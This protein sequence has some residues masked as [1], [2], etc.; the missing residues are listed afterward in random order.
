MSREWNRQVFL[1]SGY[2]ITLFTLYVD[3][4]FCCNLR[5]Y[6]RE[7]WMMRLQGRRDY[8]YGP[9][10]TLY[11]QPPFEIAESIVDAIGVEHGR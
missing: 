6:K 2:R 11:K 3:D 8:E 5:W 4:K 7:G 1:D 9:F 10:K